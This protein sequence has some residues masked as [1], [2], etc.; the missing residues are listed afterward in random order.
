MHKWPTLH[1]TCSNAH[2]SQRPVGPWLHHLR[3]CHRAPALCSLHDPPAA[4]TGAG[5]AAAAAARWADGGGSIGVPLWH[6]L[7]ACG[8]PSGLMRPGQHMPLPHIHPIHPCSVPCYCLPAHPLQGS[9]LSWRALWG[10][11]WTRTRSPAARAPPLLLQLCV[12][13]LGPFPA[14]YSCLVNFSLRCLGWLL[15]VTSRL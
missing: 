11:C 10:G 8:C 2:C 15:P 12:P 13:C 5:G 14:L 3:V 6:A 7:Q 9:A 4:R 1:T